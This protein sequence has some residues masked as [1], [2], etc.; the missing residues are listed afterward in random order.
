MPKCIQT[1]APGDGGGHTFASEEWWSVMKDAVCFTPP[2]AGKYCDECVRACMYVRLSVCEA[3]GL[4]A[5]KQHEDCFPDS[6]LHKAETY[7]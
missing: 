5:D 2:L 7:Y 3:V 1:G 6:V 4:Y